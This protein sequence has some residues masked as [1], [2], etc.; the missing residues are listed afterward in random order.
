[1]FRLTLESSAS[2]KNRKFLGKQPPDI[3]TG[4][5]NKKFAQYCFRNCFFFQQIDELS[6]WNPPFYP[7][8]HLSVTRDENQIEVQKHINNKHANELRGS[9]VNI[10]RASKKKKKKRERKKK[11]AIK[12]FTQPDKRSSQH[13]AVKLAPRMRN[14]K[15]INATMICCLLNNSTTAARNF[16]SSPCPLDVLICLSR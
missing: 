5:S 6:S 8:S 14:T 9:E 15:I 2:I 11:N 13:V 3:N 4:D 10:E 16:S 12:L 7:N 1:M